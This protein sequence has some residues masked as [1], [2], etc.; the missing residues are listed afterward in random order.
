MFGLKKSITIS[1]EKSKSDFMDRDISVSHSGED[2]KFIY[3]AK[4]ENF[5]SKLEIY[6]KPNNY[7]DKKVLIITKSEIDFKELYSKIK[8]NL[9]TISEYKNVAGLK[10]EN[11]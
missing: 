2:S 9:K 10:I 3:Y 8:E 6:I 1:N 7:P 4:S 11:L 5:L